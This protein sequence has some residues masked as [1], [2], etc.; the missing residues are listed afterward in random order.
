MYVHCTCCSSSVY[1]YPGYMCVCLKCAHMCKA[2][3]ATLDGACVSIRVYIGAAMVL[4]LD[5]YIWPATFERQTRNH[6]YVV[7][8]S[9]VIDLFRACTYVSHEYACHG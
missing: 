4:N 2:K 8:N 3:P 1:V 5:L 7:L 9:H 6:D